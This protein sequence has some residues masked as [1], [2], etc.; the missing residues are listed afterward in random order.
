MNMG[1]PS[2]P[3][4]PEAKKMNGNDA[5]SALVWRNISF[6]LVGVIISGFAAWVTLWAKAPTQDDL[7]AVE[8]R[9]RAVEQKQIE[10]HTTL[11]HL[12]KEQKT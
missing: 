7:R 8:S 12:V 6:L 10:I 2:Q 4:K 9:L 1:A 3:S 11:Q 5:S